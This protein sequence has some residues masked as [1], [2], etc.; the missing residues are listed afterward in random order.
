MRYEMAESVWRLLFMEALR[1][2]PQA[3]QCHGSLPVRS[4]V[5]TRLQDRSAQN[6]K[7]DPGKIRRKGS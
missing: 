6:R 2:R 3:T 1:Y 7:R 4:A 5:T